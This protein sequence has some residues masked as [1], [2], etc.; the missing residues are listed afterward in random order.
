MAQ[1]RSHVIQAHEWWIRNSY[2]SGFLQLSNNWNPREC[3]IGSFLVGSWVGNP[4][5]FPVDSPL[6]GN[7]K[8]GGWVELVGVQKGEVNIKTT[9]RVIFPKGPYF[10]NIQNIGHI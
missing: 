5:K 6:L 4:G 3:K 10:T 2:G 9:N 8:A 1:P 7:G